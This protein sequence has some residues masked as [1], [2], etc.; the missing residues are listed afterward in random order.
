M[1]SKKIIYE[2]GVQIEIGHEFEY[3]PYDHSIPIGEIFSIETT[4][5]RVN[6]EGL[7][8]IELSELI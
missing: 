3:S 8:F 7:D 6:E 1:R 4:Y 2:N 5:I